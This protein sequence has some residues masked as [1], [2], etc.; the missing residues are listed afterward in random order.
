MC[1]AAHLSGGRVRGR[2][3]GWGGGGGRRGWGRSHS[4]RK[5]QLQEETKRKETRKAINVV[6]NTQRR[7]GIKAQSDHE[8]LCVSVLGNIL[9]VYLLFTG[10]VHNHLTVNLFSSWT[11]AE[12]L[13]SSGHGSWGGPPEKQE[14]TQNYRHTTR[15]HERP[16]LDSK[17]VRRDK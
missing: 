9:L 11:R 1:S 3:R 15:R 12:Y 5:N 16:Q 4:R 10:T 8:C 7:S 17:Q 13:H 14:E 2:G 6:W